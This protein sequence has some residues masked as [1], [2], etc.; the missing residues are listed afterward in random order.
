MRRRRCVSIRLYKSGLPGV[1][2]F[3]T[4]NLKFIEHPA[5]GSEDG[6]MVVPAEAGDELQPSVYDLIGLRLVGQNTGQQ[7]QRVRR[8]NFITL[9]APFGR[10]SGCVPAGG[11]GCMN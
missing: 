4:G 10:I 9:G 1:N 8:N 2:L 11:I 5:L 3:A 6:R 7:M